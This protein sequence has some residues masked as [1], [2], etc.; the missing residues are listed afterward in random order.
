MDLNS[1]TSHTSL[2]TLPTLDQGALDIFVPPPKP[3]P[4]MTIAVDEYGNPLGEHHHRAKLSD[5]DV[6]LIR[7][8]YDEGMESYA[9]IAH[10][11]GVSRETVRDIV[12]FRRRATTPAGYRTVEKRATP[13]SRLEQ[14]LTDEAPD[15]LRDF[16]E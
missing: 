6:E 14:L 12:K 11:F 7:D 16:D 8:I 5:E 4:K 13:K 10:V 2:E 15:S 9:S 1:H 3:K